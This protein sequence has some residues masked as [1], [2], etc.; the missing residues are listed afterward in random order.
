MEETI[1]D[2]M[3]PT[4]NEILEQVLSGYPDYPYKKALNNLDLRRNLI[5]QVLSQLSNWHPSEEGDKSGATHAEDL[6][7]SA[8]DK[9]HIQNLIRQEIA[10]IVQ[11]KAE[12]ISRTSTEEFDSCV[13][14]SH[15]FG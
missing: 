10:Y 11:P 2:L 8:E 3:L 13:T 4:V 9:I 15:W 14:P 7:F 6:Q 5:A 12:G 1:D